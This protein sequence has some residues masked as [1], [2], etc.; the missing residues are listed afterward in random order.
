VVDNGWLGGLALAVA[1][2]YARLT[3]LGGS[4]QLSGHKP[5]PVA[6]F[7]F[8]QKLWQARLAAF[9]CRSQVQADSKPLFSRPYVL[10]GG[11]DD[12]W[13]FHQISCA[14]ARQRRAAFGRTVGA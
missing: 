10:L 12:D 8:S 14:G 13:H 6:F 9:D 5:R 7:V 1:E 11:A 4:P 3:N 2:A